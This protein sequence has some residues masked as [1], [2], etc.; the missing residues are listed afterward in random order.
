MNSS[1]I[2]DISEFLSRFTKFPVVI[3]SRSVD[4]TFLSISRD[5]MCHVTQ[6][7]RFPQPKSQRL[8]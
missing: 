1:L 7:V 2:G 4:K 8:H 3:L 5:H 6:W